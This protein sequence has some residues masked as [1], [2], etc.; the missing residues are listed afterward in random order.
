M[1]NASS[2]QRSL[3]PTGLY[4]RFRA[5]RYGESG[6]AK[7]GNGGRSAFSNEAR[8]GPYLAGK[9]ALRLL[10]REPM[11][12]PAYGLAPQ[13]GLEQVTRWLTEMS[14]RRLQRVEGHPAQCPIG[15]RYRS[16]LFVITVEQESAKCPISVHRSRIRRGL[17]SK[18]K[19]KSPENRHAFRAVLL[20]KLHRISLTGRRRARVDADPADPF[21]RGGRRNQLACRRVRLEVDPRRGRRY[22][23][24]VDAVAGIADAIGILVGLIGIG[25]R[26]AVVAIVPQP[27][28]IGI[29]RWRARSRSTR[30][31]APTSA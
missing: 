21:G 6:R 12:R 13:E 17:R 27:V 23:G 14:L 30:V 18:Q 9:S 7:W 16:G 1:T 19:E 31:S 28:R 26:R 8:D 22:R 3:Y 2:L 5:L 29:R 4:S 11:F 20:G 10:T 15:V 25:V 24:V